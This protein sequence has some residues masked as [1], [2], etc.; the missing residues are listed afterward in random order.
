MREIKELI[1]RKFTCLEVRKE[2]FYIGKKLA[3]KGN[4]M[5]SL[6]L[7]NLLG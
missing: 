3:K 6:S 7:P 5:C 4:N 2:L 1:T